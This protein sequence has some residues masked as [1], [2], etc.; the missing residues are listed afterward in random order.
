[1]FCR[2]TI[3]TVGI[4][5]GI[6]ALADANLGVHLAV[7]LHAPDDET[8]GRIIPSARRWSVREIIAAA[9]RFADKTDRY[10][11]IE[12]CMLAEVN[13]SDEQARGLAH[14]LD[15]FAAHV[16]LIPYNSIGRGITGTVYAKSSAE[17]MQR[18]MQIL[19]D[20]RVVAHFRRTRGDDVSA[21]C[22]QLRRHLI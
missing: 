1:G 14:L 13:D 11:T 7:S 19:R 18:F 4:V 21:A 15:S 22:G 5:P 16:N 6:D 3:T 10:V 20:R 9:K 17:R 12:Y 2:I 8:R